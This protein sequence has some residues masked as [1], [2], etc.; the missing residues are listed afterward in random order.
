MFPSGSSFFRVAGLNA[1][2]HNGSLWFQMCKL[3][4]TFVYTSMLCSKERAMAGEFLQRLSHPIGI[5][6][7]PERLYPSSVGLCASK[8]WQ[9]M[10]AQWWRPGI[11]FLTFPKKIGNMLNSHKSQPEQ[12]WQ[13][14]H[15]DIHTRRTFYLFSTT[16]GLEPC[17]TRHS[18]IQTKIVIRVYQLPTASPHGYMW[19]K[20]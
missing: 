14:L 9:A 2:W 16:F 10:T 17:N 4:I 8:W 1:S 15:S 13:L 20:T 7:M 5:C 6:H 11:G 12:S 19:G 3:S 18:N